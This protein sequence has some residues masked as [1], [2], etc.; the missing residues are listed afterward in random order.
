MLLACLT[1]K[2]SQE[3]RTL[4]SEWVLRGDP[5]PTFGAMPLA[6]SLQSKKEILTHDLGKVYKSDP[7]IQYKMIAQGATMTNPAC[8]HNT[9]RKHDT[10][11]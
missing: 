5:F 10:F 2:N 4:I 9:F 8:Q 11:G 1:S 6:T 7:T 3:F